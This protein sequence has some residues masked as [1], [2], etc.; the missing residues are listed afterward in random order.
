MTDMRILTITH[1]LNMKFVTDLNQLRT[2][3]PLGRCW[4]LPKTSEV[5]AG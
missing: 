3:V 5:E 2:P 4:Y 1:L